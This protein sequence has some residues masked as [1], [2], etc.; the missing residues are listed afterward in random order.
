MCFEFVQFLFFV[1]VLLGMVVCLNKLYRSVSL[2]DDL[3]LVKN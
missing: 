3:P 2:C 1:V